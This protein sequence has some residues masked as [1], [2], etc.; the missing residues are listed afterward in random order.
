MVAHTNLIV[1]K[2]KLVW[3]C[4]LIALPYSVLV[5]VSGN[6]A[7][8]VWVSGNMAAGGHGIVIFF[9]FGVLLFVICAHQA[10][11]SLII[12]DA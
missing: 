3:D 12:S 1:Y 2:K 10:K 5:W 4:Y 11:P 6:I 9:G 7:L 8:L